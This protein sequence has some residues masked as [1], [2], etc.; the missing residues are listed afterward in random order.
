[1]IRRAMQDRDW[2]SLAHHQLLPCDVVFRMVNVPGH[3]V[4]QRTTGAARSQI[5][6]TPNNKKTTCVVGPV[7]PVQLAST[8][9]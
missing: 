3:L 2:E 4:A 6:V 5:I 1:M 9:V 7:A 8:R